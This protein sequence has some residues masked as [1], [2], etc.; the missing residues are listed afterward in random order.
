MYFQIN[1][2]YNQRGRYLSVSRIARVDSGARLTHPSTRRE[3]KR[4]EHSRFDRPQ[5][6]LRLCLPSPLASSG[7]SREFDEQR[8]TRTTESRNRRHLL[9][10]YARPG[11]RLMVPDRSTQ[12]VGRI[13]SDCLWLAW[14]KGIQATNRA[15]N[16]SHGRMEDW[17]RSRFRRPTVLGGRRPSF[18]R[19]RCVRKREEPSSPGRGFGAGACVR[20]DSRPRNQIV[21][22]IRASRPSRGAE[23]RVAEP[24]LL[25]SN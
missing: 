22:R 4:E 17:S 16:G 3:K 13:E 21:E 15:T 12:P 9:C 20:A 19:V 11:V 6:S 23:R 25:T 2:Y 10:L 14:E 7:T 24:R 1:I 8:P 5:A 18:Y